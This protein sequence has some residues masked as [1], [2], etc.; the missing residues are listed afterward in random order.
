MH[1]QLPRPAIKAYEVGFLHT[2]GGIPR[3]P[4]HPSATQLV[5]LRFIRIYG[6]KCSNCC[7][8][9]FTGWVKTY[10]FQLGMCIFQIFLPKCLC[11]WILCPATGNSTDRCSTDSVC[12]AVNIAVYYSLHDRAPSIWLVNIRSVLYSLTHFTE[13]EVYTVLCSTAV[14]YLDTLLI[15]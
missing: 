14:F 4:H 7:N 9:T 15:V 1:C 8:Q 12:P 13:L 10:A 2:G 11:S 5:L 6:V 3:W